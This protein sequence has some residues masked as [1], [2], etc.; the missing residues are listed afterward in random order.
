M[1]T[2]ELI[3][4]LSE[5]DPTGEEECCVS[6]E[7]IYSVVKVPAYYDGALE[8]LERDRTSKLYNVTGITFRKSGVKI[9]LRTLSAE[10]A[11]FQD[12]HLSVQ[13]Q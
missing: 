7:D 8:I 4:L 2:K 13:S 3:K 12:P 6:N 1:K 5:L 10:I 9:V 11:L